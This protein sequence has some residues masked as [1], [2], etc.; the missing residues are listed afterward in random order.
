VSVP[1]YKNIWHVDYRYNMTT[2]VENSTKYNFI[3]TTTIVQIVK[4]T[5][6]CKIWVWHKTISYIAHIFRDANKDSMAQGQ[7]LEF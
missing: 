1:L 6:W 5:K 4:E 3:P 7:G 2:V